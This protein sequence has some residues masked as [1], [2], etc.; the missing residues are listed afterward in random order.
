[1][2]ISIFLKRKIFLFKYFKYHLWLQIQALGGKPS[3]DMGQ[4]EPGERNHMDLVY[5]FSALG[6]YV[7]NPL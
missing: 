2:R 6:E 1:M 5:D 4:M 3:L 7:S